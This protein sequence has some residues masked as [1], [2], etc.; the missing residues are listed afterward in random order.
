MRHLLR[1]RLSNGPLT[2]IQGPCGRFVTFAKKKQP[3]RRVREDAR[4]LNTPLGR[5]HGREG[6]LPLNVARSYISRMNWLKNFAGPE[7]FRKQC[8]PGSL[9]FLCVV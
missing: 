8:L 5:S 4:Y 2:D 3:Q 6:C 1:R 7:T 9:N